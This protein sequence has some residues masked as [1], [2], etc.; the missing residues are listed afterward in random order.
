[1]ELVPLPQKMIDALNK[2]LE[3]PY[4]QEPQRSRARIPT[5]TPEASLE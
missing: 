1:M 4:V 5:L 3:V 2:T